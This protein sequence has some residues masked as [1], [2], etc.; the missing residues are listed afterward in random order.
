MIVKSGDKN[1]RTFFY[2]FLGKTVKLPLSRANFGQEEAIKKCTD[3]G[4]I[5]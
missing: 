4:S 3:T 2:Q 5:F 1:L